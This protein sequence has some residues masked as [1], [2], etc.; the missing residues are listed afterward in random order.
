MDALGKRECLS[1]CIEPRFIG[2]TACSVITI[3]T[4]L[5]EFAINRSVGNT[6]FEMVANLITMVTNS[7]YVLE[8][9]TEL[10]KFW[11]C[12]LQFPSDIIIIIIIITEIN[13]CGNPLR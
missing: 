9:F 8:V 2:C 3:R 1:S 4:K 13:G 6:A 7:N 10:I 12:L 5:S 11:E